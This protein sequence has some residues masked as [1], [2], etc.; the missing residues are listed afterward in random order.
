[1]PLRIFHPRGK[2]LGNLPGNLSPDSKHVVELYTG[3]IAESATR[4]WYHNIQSEFN[5]LKKWYAR[6]E[7]VEGGERL[8]KIIPSC[9][10]N[11]LGEIINKPPEVAAQTR[12]SKQRMHIWNDLYYLWYYLSINWHHG[13]YKQS[14]LGLYSWSAKEHMYGWL[15]FNFSLWCTR[16]KCFFLI[17]SQDTIKQGKC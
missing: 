13:V 6:P 5:N 4:I 11:R 15:L 14:N 12:T 16:D 2:T 3:D 9:S 7:E 10:P 1:M 17:L 8:E